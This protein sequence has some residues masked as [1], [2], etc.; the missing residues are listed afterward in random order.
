ML[1]RIFG[2]V[3]LIFPTNGLGG[4]GT[5]LLDDL[6]SGVII[7]MHSLFGRT[8]LSTV[9]N[10]VTFGSH[11]LSVRTLNAGKFSLYGVFA[12]SSDMNLL[13]TNLAYI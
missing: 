10:H 4:K 12:M 1:G 11:M 13:Q 5:I 3:G 7:D 2:S 9:A 6:K 8:H